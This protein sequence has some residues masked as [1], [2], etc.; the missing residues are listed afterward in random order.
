[1]CP[2][3]DSIFMRSAGRGGRC[4]VSTTEQYHIETFQLASKKHSN[5]QT[6]KQ[7][8]ICSCYAGSSSSGS[9][10]SQALDLDVISLNYLLC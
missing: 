8:T 9:S 2:K 7:H 3:T 6:E 5:M 10:L 1:M 4:F